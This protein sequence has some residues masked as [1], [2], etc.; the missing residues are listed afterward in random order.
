MKILTGAGSYVASTS[1]HWEEH[2]EVPDLSCGTYSLPAGGSDSQSPHTEDE[3]YLVTRG[4][5]TLWTR[6]GTAPVRAGDVAFVPAGEEH[7]FV[8]IVED[9]AV[10][11]V[12]GPAEY[13]R[14]R[15]P[16]GPLSGS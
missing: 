16:A 5:A 9:F 14:A 12:F 13:S 2:L 7:R 6:G 8:D 11:V 15:D 1:S 4:R 10:V 3:I